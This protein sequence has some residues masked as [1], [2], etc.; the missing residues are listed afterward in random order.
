ME[1]N[2]LTV[3]PLAGR[4]EL[5][6]FLTLPYVRNDELA[7]DLD[8]G[9]RRPEWMWLALRGDRVL[10][11]LAWWTTTGADEPKMLDILDVDDDAPAAE[12]VDIGARLLRTAID[13]TLPAGTTLPE[14]IRFVPADWRDTAATRQVVED[15]MA[16]LERAGARLLVERLSLEWRPGTPVPPP[17][18]RLVFRQVEDTEE[19]LTAMTRVV[20]G[21]LDAHD[22]AALTHMSP[23]EAAV[24][25]YEEYLKTLP[26]PRGWWRLA[27]LPDGELVG[28]VLPGRNDYNAV[29][30]Y[31]GVVP[32]HRGHG[33]INDLLA[34]GTRI[35]AEQGVPRIRAATDLGNVP[36]AN[37]FRRAGYVSEQHTVNMVWD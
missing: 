8:E 2:D 15:R 37:A 32:E 24:Q 33:Y 36:M 22:V 23:R 20:H 21:T 12:R 6:L 29:I 10:A 27:A 14:Y 3:R 31:I 16:V 35:L 9:R 18:G 4:S 5:D 11:R 7:T 17:A 25:L 13:A 28:F 19:L 30:S 34:E 26:S 1:Q